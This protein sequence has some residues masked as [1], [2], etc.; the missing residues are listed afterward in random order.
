MLIE[1][2]N[3]KQ[4]SLPWEANS[5]SATSEI[6]RLLWNP[7]VHY[8]VHNSPPLA[9]NLS[10]INPVRRLQSYFSKIECN[11]IILPPAPRSSTQSLP[12]SFIDLNSVCI[13]HLYHKSY[14]PCPSHPTWFNHLNNIWRRVQIMMLFIMKFLRAIPP[15]FPSYVQIFSSASYSHTSNCVLFTVRG[16]V[17]HPYERTSRIMI[18]HILNST[19]L[20]GRRNTK[21]LYY[22][23]QSKSVR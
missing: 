7:K 12:F 19:P 22:W 10:Q 11:I 2:N 23:I 4:K 16:Q 14:T 3:S 1:L 21:S 15:L 9:L 8:R 13:S 18:W 20:N 6:P 5:R 17:S